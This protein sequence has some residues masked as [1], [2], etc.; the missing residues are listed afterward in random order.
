M[1]DLHNPEV[2]K[3]VLDMADMMTALVVG[4]LTKD[5]VRGILALCYRNGFQAG[6]QAELQHQLKSIQEVQR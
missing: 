4:M 2:P 1:N 3:P 5:E 6:R